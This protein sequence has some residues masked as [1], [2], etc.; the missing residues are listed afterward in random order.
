MDWETYN[1]DPKLVDVVAYGEADGNE[2]MTSTL[3]LPDENIQTGWERSQTPDSE[4][5]SSSLQS[6]TVSLTPQHNKHKL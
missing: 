6:L 3:L 5:V 2:A 4:G 1:I